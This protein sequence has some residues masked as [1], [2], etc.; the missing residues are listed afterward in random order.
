MAS[1]LARAVGKTRQ[2]ESILISSNPPRDPIKLRARAHK[3]PIQRYRVVKSCDFVLMASAASPSRKRKSSSSDLD[4]GSSSR[5]K[6]KD[7][8]RD[9]S[10]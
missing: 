6:S 2:T 7:S 4:N 8:E 5:K 3:R 10:K 1:R 9:A